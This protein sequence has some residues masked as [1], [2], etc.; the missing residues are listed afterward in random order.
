MKKSLCLLA[1]SLIG[2][3]YTCMGQQNVLK[4]KKATFRL[5]LDDYIS[6]EEQWVYLYGFK[7]WI[8]GNERC[9]F[10]S[11]YIKN[12][13]KEVLLEAD[14][15]IPISMHIFFEKNGPEI[16]TS[17]EPDSCV[18]FEVTENDGNGIIWKE[19]LQGE[20][21]NYEYR[22]R[23]LR[24]DFY[25]KLR[26]LTAKDEPDSIAML[27]ENWK[28]Q[29]KEAIRHTSNGGFL[30]S[31]RSIGKYDLPRDTEIMN[32]LK[33]VADTKDLEYN[34]SFQTSIGKAQPLPP[35]AEARYYSSRVRELKKIKRESLVLLD[36]N[37]GACID[38]VFS[39]IDER[40]VSLATLNTDYI[41]VDF[42]ASWCK[43][44]RQEIP[45][46]KQ[47]LGKYEND[48]SVYAISIDEKHQAWRKAI[49]QD[50]TQVFHHVIGTYSNGQPSR[51]LKRLNVKS[52]PA[53][54]LLDKNKRI[55]AKN[56]RGKELIQTLDSLMAK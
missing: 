48:L 10:D 12:S 11:V 18:I 24:E 49:E 44:C 1:F 25:E 37:I 19:A 51:L 40:K 39:D 36:T 3:A 4:S 31:L 20:M 42:W 2:L 54:F 23:K 53:N 50:S 56:L 43:P 38:L 15:P 8:S 21:N 5:I 45:Y 32:I 29:V 16:D 35:S 13:Q 14:I 28:K 7:S 26:Y 17:I 47:A 9:I 27:R 46:I 41:L 6:H 34:A 33:E 30:V 55:I 22:F 52:I